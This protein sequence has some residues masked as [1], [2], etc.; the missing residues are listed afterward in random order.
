MS[1]MGQAAAL[2]KIKVCEVVCILKSL[3]RLTRE[4]I[5]AELIALS[6]VLFEV[7]S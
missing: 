1:E 3:E 6:P 5:R 2:D 4:E 7:D